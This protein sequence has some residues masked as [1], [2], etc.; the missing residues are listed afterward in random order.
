[1]WTERAVEWYHC[2][3]GQREQSNGTTVHVDRES[4]QM[5][6]PCMWTERA[7]K[8]YHRVKNQRARNMRA[9]IYYRIFPRDRKVEENIYPDLFGRG[10]YQVYFLVIAFC[11]GIQKKKSR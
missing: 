10:K 11:Y 5:V 2:V 4:S 8:W 6:P 3:R 1:M 7:V 9:I